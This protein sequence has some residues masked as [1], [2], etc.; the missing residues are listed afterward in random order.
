MHRT[1][2]QSAGHGGSPLP[3]VMIMTDAGASPL[4]SSFAPEPAVG[5]PPPPP[6]T[7]VGPPPP[8]TTAVGRSLTDFWAGGR[9]PTSVSTLVAC[10][11]AGV[12]GG[13]M[14]AGHRLG[15]GA[16]LVGLL[17]WVPAL[18]ALVRRR[19]VG[20]LVMV[21][22]SVA[23]VAVVAFRDAGWVIGLCLAT[24]AWSGAVAGT[25]G[26]SA[27]AVVLSGFGWAVGVVR[28]FPWIARGAGSLVGPR[29]AK[30]LVALRS[31]AVTAA[32]LI[33]FGALFASADRVFASYLPR[34]DVTLLPGQ[35]VV[36]ALVALA[37]ATLAHLALAPPPWSGVGLPAGRPARLGE[38]LLPVLALAAMV[39]AFVLVQIGGLLGGN[40][41][42][43]ETEGL[44][45][46][47][48][49]REGF[50]QLVV[51][52]ALTLLVVA[53]AARRAPR[54]SERDRLLSSAA[55]GALCVGSVGVVASA[56][57]RMDLYVNAFGL[58]RLRLFVVVIEVVL[59]AV[60]VLVVV[61]GVK[62]RGGWLPRAVVQ[63]FAIAMLGLALVNPDAQIVRYNTTADVAGVDVSY[64]KG[65]SAD[66][67][68]AM[69]QLDEPLRSCL[70]DGVDVGPSMGFADWNLSRTRAAGSVAEGASMSVAEGASIDSAQ[71]A[72]CAGFYDRG[73]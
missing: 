29:R 52:T 33:V 19:A 61:A 10:G 50:A 22:L 64:L 45:Y 34:L 58:T 16:A 59:G 3:S 28:A 32:L 25:S 23:L 5:G 7:A 71:G 39:L 41:H 9:L 66:A 62:W 18:P 8:P 54:A 31:M 36:G 6:S 13:A 40:R 17:V 56:L 68:P 46:A 42:V 65:L 63:V 69:E 4:S 35:V 43:L 20:E 24:A 44:T 47:E 2:R 38:W 57:R 11:V 14:V 72:A 26:R 55:L 48:Y 12:V 70:L 37:A 49:A 21:A 27:P 30:V 67:V 73:H 53:I 1:T 15:L 51:A 60:L